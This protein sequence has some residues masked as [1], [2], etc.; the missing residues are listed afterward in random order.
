MIVA[1]NLLIGA[2]LFCYFL[3]EDTKNVPMK[4]ISNSD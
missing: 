3:I 2:F 4:I 1:I